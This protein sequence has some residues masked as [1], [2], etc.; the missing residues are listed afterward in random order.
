MAVHGGEQAIHGIVVFFVDVIGGSWV[1]DEM[2][3]DFA[4]AHGWVEWMLCI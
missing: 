3:V 2:E 1:F 4:G